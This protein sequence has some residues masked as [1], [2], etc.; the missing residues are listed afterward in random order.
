MK[1]TLIITLPAPEFKIKEALLYAGYREES[2][3]A[4]ALILGAK[5]EIERLISYKACYRK[6]DLK[7]DGDICR[8]DEIE[9]KSKNLARRL[10]G[11][12]GAIIFTATVGIEI[13]RLIKRYSA[14]NPAK[15][16]IIGAVANERIESLC[17]AL[18]EYFREEYGEIADRFSPGYGDL[19]LDFQKEIFAA[20]CPEK[21]IGLYLNESI[22]M[23]PVKSVSAIVGIKK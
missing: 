12:D 10:T 16:I 13:D 15:A 23:T 20:L 14:T 6:F 1:N 11:C 17:D 9:A 4:N 22:F 8:F 21:N 19:A 18:C 2:E 3:E 7:I 5:E